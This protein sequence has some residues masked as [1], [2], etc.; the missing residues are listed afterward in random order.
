MSFDKD[1]IENLRKVYNSEHSNQQPIPEGETSDVW[2]SLKTRFH[3]ECKTGKAEC[4]FA[5]MLS[6][7]KAP[8]SWTVNPEEWLSS[9][10]I[11]SIENQYMK[12]FSKYH[13]VGSFPIDFDKR[14]KTGACLVSS[15]CSMNIKSLYDSGYTQIGIVFNTDVSSGPGQ[16]WIALFCDI[17]P[18]LDFPRIT[19]FDSY[20][21][22]PEPQIQKLMKRWKKQWDST[23]IHSSPMHMTYNKTKHQYEDSECGMYCLYFHYCCLAGISMEQRIPDTVVRGMRGMLFRVGKK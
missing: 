18:E 17:S 11:D 9:D 7:P 4:I 12:V 15:L 19:Y 6:R 8:N 21:Q 1:E 23:G 2:N 14:S 20:A 10:D 5:S 13:Y 3:K 22:E 16:H